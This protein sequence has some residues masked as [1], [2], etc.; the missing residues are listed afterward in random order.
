MAITP[1]KS[2]SLAAEKC[3]PCSGE[4]PPMEGETL[5][6]FLGRLGG[7]WALKDNH[8]EKEFRFR[9][10]RGALGFTNKVGELAESVTHHPDIHLAWGKVKVTIWTD[11]IGGLSTADFV[12]AAKIDELPR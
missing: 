6:A 2:N 3:A 7:G 5:T 12:L 4:Q 10:F 11:K 9:D 1:G 8:L